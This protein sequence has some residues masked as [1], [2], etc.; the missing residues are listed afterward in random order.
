MNEYV[1]ISKVAA[2]ENAY[3]PT[4]EMSDFQPGHENPGVS[5][6]VSYTIT[7]WLHNDIEV[8]R[9]LYVKRDTRNG[10]V[11]PGIFNTSPVKEIE[12]FP[13]GLLFHT[14]NSVYRLEWI[15]EVP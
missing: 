12:P 11:M 15:D 3:R 13:G 9:S 5:L 2:E 4:P 1:K 6:P 7:G 14:E 10:V 8:G